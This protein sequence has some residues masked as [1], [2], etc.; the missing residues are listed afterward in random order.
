KEFTHFLPAAPDPARALRSFDQLL[1]RLMSSEAAWPL[2]RD[3]NAL[4]ELAQL[5]GSSAFLWEDLLR[6]HIEQL[7]PLLGEWRTR[8]L[9]DRKALRAEIEQRLRDAPSFEDRKRRLNAFKDEEM[10]VVD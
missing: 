10:L 2:F 6:R 7:A 4:R 8:G 3:G 5:L 1:D 9:R